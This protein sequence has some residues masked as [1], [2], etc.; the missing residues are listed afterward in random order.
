MRF[1]AFELSA[2]R[3]ARHQLRGSGLSVYLRHGTIDI[4]VFKEV[5]GTEFG[6]NAYE[7]P[8][9]VA[10]ALDAKPQP[11]VLDL[12]GNIGLFGV[13][14][15]GRWPNASLRSFEPDPRNLPL[16]R[17]A[18]AAN[19]LERRWTVDAAAVANCAGEMPFLAGLFAESQLASVADPATRPPSWAPL[20]DSETVMV[21]TVDL[22][23]ED[24]HVDLIKMDIEGGE[25]A[26]L[27]DPRLPGLDADAIVVE[28]HKAG[29]PEPDPRAAASRLLRGAG[30]AHQHETQESSH[31]G[32]VWGWRQ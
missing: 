7:P 21:R 18:I 3:L 17:R 8:A 30:Y 12:G 19:R 25:W 10:A 27:T 32:V 2:P 9:P 4:D 15:L 22:F 13:Y 20:P 23:E 11:T 5:F 29:C 24:R 26:I 28:W 6:P 16:L 1:L 31:S 14:A